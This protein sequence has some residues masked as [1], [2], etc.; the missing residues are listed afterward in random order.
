MHRAVIFS[1]SV[2]SNGVTIYGGLYGGDTESDILIAAHS[3]YKTLLIREQWEGKRGDA[4]RRQEGWTRDYDEGGTV[5]WWSYD[6]ERYTFNLGFDPI[7][8]QFVQLCN[9]FAQQV[10]II[11][12]WVPLRFADTDNEDHIV[13][14]VFYYMVSNANNIQWTDVEEQEVDDLPF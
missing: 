11:S 12:E 3:D 14:G 10:A 9:R 6:K 1:N 5:S 7:P 2:V 8:D 13:N 4:F